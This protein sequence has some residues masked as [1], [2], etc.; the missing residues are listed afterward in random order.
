[1]ARFGTVDFVVAD[2]EEG[3][4]SVRDFISVELQAVDIT[5]SYL[6]SYEAAINSRMME[7]RPSYGFNWANVRK[8]FVSQLISKGFHH[9]HWG[10]RIVAVLQEDLF[11]QFQKHAKIPTVGIGEA[12][13]VFLLYQFTLTGGRWSMSFRRAVPATHAGVMTASLYETPPSRSE[14]EARILSRISTT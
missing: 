8:R 9:H 10:T 12:N 14:F 11:G 1:M 5:G 6:P 7:R 13:I 3:G 2:L 4:K